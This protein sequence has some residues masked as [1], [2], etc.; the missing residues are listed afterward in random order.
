ML[1]FGVPDSMQAFL[2][3]ESDLDSQERSAL[4]IDWLVLG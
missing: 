4:W 3:V 2:Q 1:D